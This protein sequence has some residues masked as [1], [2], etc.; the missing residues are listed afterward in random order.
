MQTVYMIAGMFLVTFGIRYILLPLSGNYQLPDRLQGILK[1]APPA[2]LTAII[3][4]AALIPDGHHLHL[5]ASNPYLVGSICTVLI[6][7]FSKNLLLTI[8]GGMVSFG[9]CQ[10]ILVLLH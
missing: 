9:L 3:V 5:S 2:V 4:P 7:W 10:W 1:Y 6:G 8:V